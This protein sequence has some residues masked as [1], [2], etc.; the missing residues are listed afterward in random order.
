MKSILKTIILALF[1]PILV[2][3]ALEAYPYQ[4]RRLILEKDGKIIKVVDLI[5][6]I[7]VSILHP[8]K[9]S[10]SHVKGLKKSEHTI[11]N[12]SER[13]LLAT[14]RKI[15]K[16]PSGETVELFLESSPES[17]L[18]FANSRF[19]N[20]EWTKPLML[21]YLGSELYNEC[22]ASNTK[23]ICSDAD[24]YRVGLNPCPTNPAKEAFA[25][26]F[27]LKNS[28]QVQENL[29][30]AQQRSGVETHKKLKALWDDYKENALDPICDFVEQKSAELARNTNPANI[31][32]TQF[33]AMEM[34]LSAQYGQKFINDSYMSNP[35]DHELLHKI[36]GSTHK[37][38]IIYAGGHH[39]DFIERKLIDE[40]NFKLVTEI[41]MPT[42]D[43]LKQSICA[44]IA[45]TAWG[46]LSEN[47]KL[48][49]HRF[50]QQ[51]IYQKM[52][53]PN[54]IQKY[55]DLFTFHSGEKSIDKIREMKVLLTIAHKQ[56]IDL[57][58]WTNQDKDGQTLLH[59]HA[60][61]NSPEI[62]EFLLE[63]HSVVD[64]RALN[65]FTPLHYA[66]RNS[67]PDTALL[68]IKAGANVHA[69]SFSGDTPAECASEEL[70]AQLPKDLRLAA[71]LIA[72]KAIKDKIDEGSDE[73][74]N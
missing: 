35:M 50:M 63:H 40:F 2:P 59:A 42:Q 22:K 10:S 29:A 39:C 47:P 32:L 49:W 71:I 15:A 54:F 4:F 68:L 27:N 67:N 48:S 69:K 36:F 31:E 26:L 33:K 38:N 56:H 74:S 18:L 25:H 44:P 57:L 9:K 66:M 52:V 64:P 58:H 37:H 51:G 73:N 45:H 61:Q 14:L 23:L 1:V 41:G 30:Q 6:D 5:S 17:R 43:A 7:H 11:F 55:C 20:N 72:P 8:K 19:Y 13:S 21:C 65:N 24:R 28:T 34:A 12:P 3:V 16:R 62:A 53:D 60:E 70:L 46:F